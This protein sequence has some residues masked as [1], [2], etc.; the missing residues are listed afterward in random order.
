MKKYTVLQVISLLF[1][2][3]GWLFLVAGVLF[4]CGFIFLTISGGAAIGGL[5]NRGGAGSTFGALFGMLGLVQGIV[6]LVLSLL[7]GSFMIAIGELISLAVD[8]AQNSQRTTFL[9][10]RFVRSRS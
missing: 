7:Q 10:D 4:S 1:R 6:L 3:F 9:V 5:E 8:I 2:I